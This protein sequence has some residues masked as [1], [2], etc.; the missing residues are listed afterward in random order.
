M[1][2]LETE[3]ALSYNALS[4][5]VVRANMASRGRGKERLIERGS[6]LII[7]SLEELRRV[8]PVVEAVSF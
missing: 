1:S 7:G 5:C 4:A 2:G 8:D 3:E 6:A